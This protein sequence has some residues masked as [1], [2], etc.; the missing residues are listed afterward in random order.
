[1]DRVLSPPETMMQA[2]VVADIM[3]RSQRHVLFTQKVPRVVQRLSR[4]PRDSEDREDSTTDPARSEPR[5][6]QQTQ[7]GQSP[8]GQTQ[9]QRGQSPEG[10]TRPSCGQRPR[11]VRAQRGQTDPARSEPSVSVKSRHE[12]VPQP[13]GQS[14]SRPERLITQ[15]CPDCFSRPRASRS[16][17]LGRGVGLVFLLCAPSFSSLFC[18]FS[19]LVSR[20][21]SR[22][23]RCAVATS[24][25]RG[26]SRSG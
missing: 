3:D 15:P 2:S 8:E 14:A 6:P 26:V 19:V 12:P 9:T 7:R 17:S 11:V 21:L 5:G 22:S 1:M 24:A 4:S 18:R 23:R 16:S 20:E 10:Q 13:E 25:I